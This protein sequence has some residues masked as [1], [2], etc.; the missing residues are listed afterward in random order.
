M[1]K[2]TIFAVLTAICVSVCGVEA[3]TA[4]VAGKAIGYTIE[5]GSQVLTGHSGYRDAKTNEDHSM[6]EALGDGAVTTVVVG[7][8]VGSA[9]SAGAGSLAGYAGLA[10]A[11]SNLGLGGATTAIAG[12]MG[13]SATGAAA[14]TLVTSAVGGPVVMGAL[15][16]VGT[17]AVGYG[18]YKGSQAVWNLIKD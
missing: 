8:G 12:A 4:G 10:S 5:A 9:M 6:T 11:V 1:N 7:Y 17:A 18:V 14:T 3:A 13:S 15:I 2:K 16:V